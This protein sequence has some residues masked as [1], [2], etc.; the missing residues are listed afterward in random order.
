[1]VM[2]LYQ[3]IQ[4]EPVT[5]KGWSTESILC[6]VATGKCVW[7]YNRLKGGTIRDMADLVKEGDVLRGNTAEL[8]RKI[9][10]FEG[11][12]ASLSDIP[13][14]LEFTKDF[15]TVLQQ[16]ESLGATFQFSAFENGT[17]AAGTY[18]VKMDDN[19]VLETKPLPFRIGRWSLS[20]GDIKNLNSYVTS[21]NFK[22]VTIDKLEIRNIQSNPE[23]A[24][25]GSYAVH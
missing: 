13:S 22:T 24:L 4:S 3:F 18:D 12:T 6:T 7:K 25:E 23:F 5:Y 19:T 14:D 15:G 17:P 16:M 8:H 11:R 9:P 21:L 20:S 1:M 2:G 10:D